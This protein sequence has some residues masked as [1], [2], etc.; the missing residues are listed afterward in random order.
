MTLD[1]ARLTFLLSDLR[2]N[3]NQ[4]V[5]CF[6]KN[7]EVIAKDVHGIMPDEK[8]IC[9]ACKKIWEKEKERDVRGSIYIKQ[10][11]DSYDLCRLLSG[12]DLKCI[13]ME[14]GIHYDC[15]HYLDHDEL[16]RQWRKEHTL[17]NRVKQSLS[18]LGKIVRGSAPIYCDECGEQVKS[19]KDLIKC[20]Y[21]DG[22]KTK[23]IRLCNIC[24]EPPD[25]NY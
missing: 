3:P 5:V 6:F 16:E 20:K 11:C 14:E 9:K 13:H 4:K 23:T 7:H 25:S 2:K 1:Y 15:E 21:V 8:Y 10:R 24:T 17:K 19:K 22:K 12:C 18:L